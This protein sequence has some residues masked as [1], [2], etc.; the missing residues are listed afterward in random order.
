MKSL[1]ILILF[2][3]FNLSFAHKTKVTEKTYNNIHTVVYTNEYTES[4]NIALI[5]S[6]YAEKLSKELG[7]KKKI[8]LYFEENYFEDNV[9]FAQIDKHKG[10]NELL[11]RFKIKDFSIPKSLNVI[12]YSISNANELNK[13]VNFYKE[14]YYKER[15]SKLNDLLNNRVLRPTD[16]KE[17]NKSDLVSYYFQNDDFNFY[18]KGNIEKTIVQTFYVADYSILTYDTVII[19][20]SNNEMKLLHNDSVK[21]LSLKDVGDLYFPYNIK[22]LG[23]KIFFSQESSGWKANRVAVYDINKDVLVQ[24]LD[25]LIK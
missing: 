5:A 17:L 4:I 24:N 1:A 20:E 2:F 23:N 16:I 10:K 9:I 21:S 11:I 14:L 13:D 7:Y 6:Q 22:L 15:S 19:V 12:E 8:T 18:K 3:S 25:D